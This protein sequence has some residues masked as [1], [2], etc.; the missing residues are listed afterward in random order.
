MDWL[1]AIR[2]D[3]PRPTAHARNLFHL[4]LAM[5]DAWAAYDATASPFLSREH[6]SL[7]RRPRG[8]PQRGHQLRRVPPPQ[9]AVRQL[10]RRRG[11]VLVVRHHQSGA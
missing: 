11:L 6:A 4:S 3:I 9:G 7:G 5:Y 1:S 8:G 10:S 2:I